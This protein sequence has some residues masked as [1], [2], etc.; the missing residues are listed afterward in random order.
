MF[1][2]C[3]VH[4]LKTDIKC[5]I[6]KTADINKILYGSGPQAMG[7]DPQDGITVGRESHSKINGCFASNNP[8]ERLANVTE[9]V[10]ITCLVN[11][12]FLKNYIL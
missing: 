9:S 4:F 1:P 7:S 8:L 10:R 3:S 11:R 12:N 5:R 6:T 2:W